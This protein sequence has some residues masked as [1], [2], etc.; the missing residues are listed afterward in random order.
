MIDIR[1]INKAVLLYAL[2]KKK[3][4][5][6]SNEFF[7]QTLSKYQEM[8]GS[9]RDGLVF[10]WSRRGRGSIRVDIS[11]DTLDPTSYDNVY[12]EGSAAQVVESIRVATMEVALKG[13]SVQRLNHSLCDFFL[14]DLP[15]LKN[16]SY[17]SGH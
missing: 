12:G 4:I 7:D 1:G 9:A 15:D 14:A 3:T 11:H 5:A 6:S 8:I 17:Y 13:D 16:M 10:T 2:L